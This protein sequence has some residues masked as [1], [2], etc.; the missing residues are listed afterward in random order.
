MR[1]SPTRA[2]LLSLVLALALGPA[3]NTPV[4]SAPEDTV[5][6]TVN[7]EVLSRTDFEQELARELASTDV[8][9]R[10]PEEIEPFKRTLLDTYI[11]R[12][13]LLQAARKNNLTV[14]PEEVDRGVLRL[15]GDYP[16]GN[17]NEVL[18]QGQ[19]S[20]AELRAREASRLTIEKLF[21]SHVYS[22]VA[23]TEEEL[24]AYYSAHEAELNESEQVHA[25]QIVVKGLDEARRVQAQLK[26]GKKFADLARR[27]SLSADAKVGGD[28]GFF[29]RGQMPPAF[30]EVVFKL[31][32]GQVSDVVS[33]EYGYHLFKVLERK[34]ARKRDFA[35]ARQWV[36]AKLLEHKRTEAQEAFEKDLRD[37]AQVQVN[38][39]TLQA[40]RGVPAV[41][42]QAAK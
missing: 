34:P 11:H 40:I 42:P 13:L 25:A 7:G 35:E 16:A 22:R 37:K 24:R 4:K 10:T 41:V 6:A 20:M 2:P 5:V 38:E 28:L 30:D 21:A 32:V 8:S 15:S 3:C 39:A 31:G 18:A 29:P 1:F 23:V 17:F 19:L 9:Q 27:Y 33:T 36:E 26:S 14:T 12:M